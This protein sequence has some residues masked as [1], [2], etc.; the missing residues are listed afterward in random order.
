MSSD[1]PARPMRERV[2]PVIRVVVIALSALLLIITARGAYDA[3]KE[4][5]DRIAGGKSQAAVRQEQ[6]TRRQ[7]ESI[8]ADLVG[9]VP[10][11][12][13]IYV[14][15]PRTLWGLRLLEFAAIGGIEVTT[16]RTQ[17]DLVATVVPD[18]AAPQKVR[19]VLE[20]AR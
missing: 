11:Q 2:T 13:V 14:A 4:G 6:L 17:A 9:Q 12:N 15:E 20:A 5:A 16:D 10:P 3:A 18:E 7:I 1:H 19:L 8:N